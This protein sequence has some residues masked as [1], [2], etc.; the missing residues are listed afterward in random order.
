MQ[1]SNHFMFNN[2]VEKDRTDININQNRENSKS[3]LQWLGL[4][5]G[6]T[7]CSSNCVDIDNQI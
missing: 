1:D 2:I 6:C 5:F 3:M 4:D 7:N